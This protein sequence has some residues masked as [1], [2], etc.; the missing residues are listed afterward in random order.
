MQ[1]TI[2]PPPVATLDPPK[3]EPAEPSRSIFGRVLRDRRALIDEIVG[4]KRI[5]LT[6]VVLA[7]LGL[8]ALGGLAL[9]VASPHAIQIPLAALKAP[10]IGLGALVVCFP[11]FYIFAVLLGS[12]LSVGK[13]LRLLAV[14]MGLRGAIIAGLAPLLLF[15]ASVGS[16]YGFLLVAGLV[17][18]GLAEGAFLHTVELGV[19]RLRD[20]GDSI[21]LAFTR[22]WMLI[23]VAVIMQ[24]T[25]SLRP[26]IG[27][28]QH[29]ANICHWALIGGGPGGNMFTH[30][31]S[32][33]AKM[34]M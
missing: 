27:L 4:G 34:I 26:I 17:T 18:F 31:M 30:F 21:S 28:C 13:A 20:A 14:G 9:G 32:N 16:P 6:R 5:D 11:A 22:G 7:G 15:F 1:S 19:K 3:L 8:T 12:R 33:V 2:E 24:F 25:W 10:L 23:Y 29:D